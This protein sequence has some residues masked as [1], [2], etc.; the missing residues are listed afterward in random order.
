MGGKNQIYFLNF[1]AYAT[2]KKSMYILLLF[3]EY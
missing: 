2:Q 3:K 1:A